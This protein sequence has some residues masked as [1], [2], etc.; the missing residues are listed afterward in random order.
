VMLKTDGPSVA[1]GAAGL[2]D[3]GVPFSKI[4]EYVDNTFNLREETV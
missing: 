4:A 2:N 3:R 1:V